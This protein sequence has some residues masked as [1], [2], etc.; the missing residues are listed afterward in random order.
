[1]GEGETTSGRLYHYRC[2]ELRIASAI[3]FPELGAETAPEDGAL[4]VSLSAG[5][6]PEAG[7]VEREWRM[8]DGSLWTTF[9]RDGADWLVTFP[10]Y[11]AF[12]LAAA[13]G[14]VEAFPR[15]AVGLHTL[16]HLLLN[17]IFPLALCA[18]GRHTFHA[19]AVAVD[20]RAA[21][22]SGVS[23]AGKS[24]LALHFAR[25]GSPFLSDDLVIFTPSA[26]GVRVHPS[27]PSLRVFP[28]SLRG[29]GGADVETIA[30]AEYS[31]KA[32]VLAGGEVAFQSD[33]APLG[34]LYLIGAESDRVTIEAVAGVDAVLEL[35]R[36]SFLLD[37][38]RRDYLRSH[39]DWAG[40]LASTGR[41]FRLAYPR[42]F[43][44]LEETRAAIAAHLRSLD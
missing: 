36:A 11:A 32:R 42:D 6:V 19:S 31:D 41:L 14:A 5:G 29:A 38:S 8:P 20:G 2:G 27:Y 33:P 44:R 23:G 9:Q 17:Q 26:T 34:A 13:G 15:P 43:A 35:V 40:E 12:R 7:P 28:D 16:R 25:H 37:P 18:R 10:D 3:P 21:V 1:V 22:F 39:L 30:S 24:T 4:R